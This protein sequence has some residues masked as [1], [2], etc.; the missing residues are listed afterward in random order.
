MSFKH[1]PAFNL[2]MTWINYFLTSQ[3]LDF[4]FT[5]IRVQ[6][7]YKALLIKFGM[8]RVPK[9]DKFSK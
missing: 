6:Q 3:I 4:S 8:F 1:E 7:K 2:R 5:S 9:F